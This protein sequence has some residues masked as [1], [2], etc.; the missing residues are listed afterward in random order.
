MKLL[1]T[2]DLHGKIERL[3]KVIQKHQDVD[4]HLNA[5]DMCIP[6]QQFQSDVISVKG[7]NDYFIDLPNQ[8]ILTHGHI[9]ILVTHGH[10]ERV[11]MT[12]RQLKNKARQAK[13]HICI[14]GHTHQRHQSIEDGIMFINPG[15]LGDHQQSYAIYEEGILTFHTLD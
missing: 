15:A 13:V 1:I 11:K 2:S 7:N 5:G 4:L 10:H 6:L 8:R 3:K 9:R 14:F 12:M